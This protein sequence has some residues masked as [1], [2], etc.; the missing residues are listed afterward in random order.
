M[1]HLRRVSQGRISDP[2]GTL[3]PIAKAVGIPS[4]ALAS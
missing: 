1:D 4:R 3:P 2:S